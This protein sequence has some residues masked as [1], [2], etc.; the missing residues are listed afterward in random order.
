M[1]PLKRFFR[2]LLIGVVFLT[3]C[4][5]TG[6]APVSPATTTPIASPE[7]TATK[8]PGTPS[9]PGNSILWDDLQ[10]T[11][12]QIEITQE[13]I[14]D[15]GS[16]RKPSPGRKF[17]WVHI[18]LN[19]TGQT[20]MEVPVLEHYSILYAGTEIKSIY[21]HRNEYVDYVTL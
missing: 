18:Q 20:E 5:P 13:Y 10:V 6:E 8:I 1:F 11:M 9:S 3:A 14:T 15:F 16:T 19:N 12:D 21:S 4:S 7:A 17:L 2:T